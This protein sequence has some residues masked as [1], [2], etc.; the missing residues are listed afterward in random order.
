MAKKII[1]LTKKQTQNYLEVSY[2]F[3]LTVPSGQIP[4]RV[5][6]IQYNT[7]GDV[8]SPS[9]YKSATAGEIT[10]INAGQ[11]VEQQG[12]TSY[13]SNVTNNQIAAD[14]IAKFNVAQTSLS[15]AIDFNYYG[16]FWDGT[17]W[18]MGGV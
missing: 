3:W 16:S 18:T 4:F 8:I 10:A 9:V 12:M 14:L 2:L 13:S 5:L 7:H 17:T 11:V 15:N 6:P 1:I